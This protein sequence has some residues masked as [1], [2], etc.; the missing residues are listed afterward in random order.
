MAKLTTHV[1]DLSTG[2]PAAGMR[3]RLCRGTTTIA[4]VVTNRDG[5]C[6]EPLLQGEALQPGFYELRFQV[7]AYFAAMETD[8]PF[9]DEVPIAFSVEA[10][11]S[12]HVPLLCTPWSYSTYRGS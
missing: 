9:L 10:G 2:I 11:E 6:D 5:R 7:G 4:E 3:V 8:C 12:Y 1:L